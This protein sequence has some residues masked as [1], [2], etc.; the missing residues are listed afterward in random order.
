MRELLGAGAVYSRQKKRV[1]WHPFR[2]RF[3][4]LLAVALTEL[5]DL[6]RGLQNVL[7]A[8]VKRVRLARNFKFQ[9]WI[10]VTVFPLDGFPGRDGRP[11]QDRKLRRNVLEHD[12]SIFGVNVLFHVA[13]A[14]YAGVKGREF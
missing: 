9:Q 14:V 13:I 6:F 8:R 4:H 10:L 5:V 2:K 7:L 11:G 3:S 1:P 12:V